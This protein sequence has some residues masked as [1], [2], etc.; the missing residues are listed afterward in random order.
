MRSNNSKKTLDR[1]QCYKQESKWNC[2]Y[3]SGWK[4]L[5]QKRAKR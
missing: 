3:Y 2:V 1:K 4:R 5:R